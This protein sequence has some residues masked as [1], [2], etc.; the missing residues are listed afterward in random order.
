[1]TMAQNLSWPPLKNTTKLPQNSS[2][3]TKSTTYTF[4]VNCSQWR[5][6]GTFFFP[7]PSLP[8]SPKIIRRKWESSQRTGASGEGV[9]PRSWPP[10][11]APRQQLWLVS[12][13]E[14]RPAF[15]NFQSIPQVP[16][17]SFQIKKRKRKR[18]KG[19]SPNS[20][21]NA[22]SVAPHSSFGS[23]DNR[24]KSMRRSTRQLSDT[25]WPCHFLG[26]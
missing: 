9:S 26:N 1:M 14:T 23:S 4:V 18:K 20:G 19:R 7:C 5:C 22:G 21:Q 11:Q 15:T 10:P 25:S 3:R 24:E 12:Q 13:P 2:W 6:V 8:E 17:V 16:E